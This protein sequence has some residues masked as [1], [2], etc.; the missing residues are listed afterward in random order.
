[1]AL[2]WRGLI[3]EWEKIIAPILVG[4]VVWF[5]NLIKDAI[6]DSVK[7]LKEAVTSNTQEL[8]VLN[9]K[10]ESIIEDT[11]SIPKMKDDLNVL[12]AW[13]KEQGKP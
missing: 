7:S 12:H 13:R 8:A 10:I 5:L 11:K 4:V 6:K 2:F 1:M 3:V 9:S